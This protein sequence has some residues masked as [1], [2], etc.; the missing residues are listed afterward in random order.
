MKEA[1]L[2]FLR[3][4]LLSGLILS[5]CALPAFAFYHPDQ[6]RWLSRDPIEEEGGANL[7]AF[8]LNDPINK[9]DPLGLDWTVN[10]SGSTQADADCKCDKVEELAKKIGLAVGDYQKW[11][12]PADGKGLPSSASDVMASRKFKTPNTVYAYWAGALH[13]VGKASVHWDGSVSHLNGLGFKV[14]SYEH[15]VG[16]YWVLNSALPSAANGRALHGLYYWGHG[17]PAGLWSHYGNYLGYSKDPVLSY[18]SISLPY[19]MGLGL[20]FACYSNSGKASLFSNAPGSIWHGYS[21]VL[22]PVPFL[23]TYHVSNH[24]KAGDQGTSP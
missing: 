6:G 1:S 3:S 20:M 24:I 8:V 16:N 13:G 5:S 12:S 14:I 4:S 10:R 22:V 2:G 9:V 23:N 19:K 21:G 11:L 17:G 7:N 18:G 15:S